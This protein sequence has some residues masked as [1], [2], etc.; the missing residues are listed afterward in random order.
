VF[1]I[2]SLSL[3]GLATLAICFS[4]LRTENVLV[5]LITGN[6]LQTRSDLATLVF[7]IC[8]GTLVGWVTGLA[9]S[10][11]RRL[12]IAITIVLYSGISMSI[13]ALALKDTLS[14]YL[15]NPASSGSSGLIAKEASSGWRIRKV[16]DLNVSPTS[17]AMSG[18]NEILVAGYSGGYFQNGAILKLRVTQEGVQQSNIALGLTRP[19]GVAERNGKIYVSRAGQYSKAIGGRITQMNTGCITE[20]QDLDGD[21]IYEF[22]DDII[23]GLPGAQL[24]DGLHQN[25]NIAFLDDGTLLVTVGNPN[26]HSPPTGLVDGNILKVNVSDKTYTIFATGFRNPFGLT[27]SGNGKIFCTDNDSNDT[28]LGDRLIEVAQGGKYGHPFRDSFGVNV[29]GADSIL[30]RLSSAQGIASY[31]SGV[32]ARDENKLVVASY[33]DDS[34][35]WITLPAEGPQENAQKVRVDFLAKIP[36]PVAV[37]CSPNGVIFACSYRERALYE[38]RRDK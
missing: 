5:Q 11:D 19:H 23:D 32:D 27:V 38:I 16:A 30:T 35:N 10:D 9:I 2:V 15:S 22:A 29:T 13:A 33:G 18:P 3:L 36:S 25:N 24:P 8:V 26:D 31:P 7:S 20:L 6:R 37:C 4:Q 28:N 14:K 12:R 1:S 17:M 34:I 21:G